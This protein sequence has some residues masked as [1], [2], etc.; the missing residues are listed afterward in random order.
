MGQSSPTTTAKSCDERPNLNIVVG[1]LQLRNGE[2]SQILWHKN[3]HI[4]QINNMQM[5]MI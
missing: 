4:L 3:V 1:P 2:T 5:N